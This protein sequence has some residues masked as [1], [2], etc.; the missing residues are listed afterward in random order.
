VLEAPPAAAPDPEALATRTGSPTPV[1]RAAPD[2]IASEA[3]RPKWRSVA[4]ALLF[5]L[6]VLLIVGGG[7]GAVGWYAHHTYFVA[8]KG[9]RVVVYRGVP[10]GIL[11]WKPTVETTTDL[12][13]SKLTPAAVDQVEASGKGSL[14]RAQQFVANLE[15]ATTTTTTTT[16]TVPSPTTTRR[17]PPTTAK[18][19]Q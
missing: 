5:V 18:G 16:T 13:R 10:G 1:P 8:F 6:P 11:G 3:R 17:S 15:A 19:G 2:I 9:D 7:I 4:G 14:E 12:R